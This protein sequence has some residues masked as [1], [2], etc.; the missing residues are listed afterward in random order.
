MSI[1]TR[2][3]LHASLFRATLAAIA[4]ATLP[5]LAGAQGPIVKVLKSGLHTFL[6]DHAAILTVAELGDG[7]PSSQVYVEFRDAADQVRGTGGGLLVR[8]RPVRVRVQVSAPRGELLR[9]IVKILPLTDI[10][11]SEPAITF[12]D[13]DVNRLTIIPHGPCASVSFSVQPGGDTTDTVPNCPE[14]H[15]TSMTLDPRGLPY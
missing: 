4:L 12:E 6:V 9:A 10:A 15:I 7:A 2:F 3:R 13:L 8:G 1:V 5:A 11:A 14:F